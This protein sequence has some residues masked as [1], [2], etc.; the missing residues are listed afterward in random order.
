MVTTGSVDCY[1]IR[2]IFITFIISY[3]CTFSSVSFQ[4]NYSVVSLLCLMMYIFFAT[5]Y[6]THKNLL[7]S[8]CTVFLYLLYKAPTKELRS[9]G[10]LHSKQWSFLTDVSGQC[11]SPLLRVHLSKILFV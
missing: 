8:S 5:V 4:L 3:N 6:S 1:D 2:I 7:P 10:L 9:S 11:I